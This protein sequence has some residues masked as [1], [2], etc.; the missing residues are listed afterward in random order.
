MILSFHIFTSWYWTCFDRAMP[1]FYIWLSTGDSVSRNRHQRARPKKDKPETLALISKC[2]RVS[3]IRPAAVLAFIEVLRRAAFTL[4]VRRLMV[5]GC[6]CGTTNVL[7]RR[8]L[9]EAPN[10]NQYVETVPRRGYRF[11]AEVKHR[12]DEPGSG[13]RFAYE[14]DVKPSETDS[15]RSTSQ[16]TPTVTSRLTRRWPFALAGL[17]VLFALFLLMDRQ[18]WREHIFS[19]ESV[20][21]QSLAVL[22]LEDLSSEGSE[23]YLA[24]RM[25]DALITNLSKVSSLRVSSRPSVM[26]YKG[27]HKPLGEI[28]RELNV[29]A[30]LTGSVVRSGGRMRITIQL[31]HA[32]T[33]RNLWANSYERELSDV[34]AIQSD[35]TRDIV[36]EIRVK[37]LPQEQVRFGNV[38]PVNPEAF[39]QYLRGQFYLHRQKKGDNETAINALE[40]AVALDNTFAPAYA[41]LSQAYVWKLFL[42]GPEEKQLSEKAFVAAEKAVSLDPDLAVA[43]LARGRL[44]WTPANRFPHENAIQEYNRALALNPNLDEARNQLAL[45]YCHIGAFNEAL[46]ESRKAITINPSNTLAQFRIGQTLNFQGKYEEALTVL[47]AIPQDANPALVGHQIA[48]SLFNLGRREEAATV[49]EN[50]IKEHPED[51]GGL[52]TSIQAVLAASA[53]QRGIAV[54]KIRSAIE[55]GKGFGHFHHT[56]YHIA[57]A[58]AL[59]NKPE[60]AITWLKEAADDGF[61]CYPLFQNDRNLDNMRSDPRFAE[62]MSKLKGQWEQYKVVL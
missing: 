31:A 59:L 18:G 19:K 30:V 41:E 28:G 48:W 17:L 50:L 54:E 58:Y 62:L 14:G 25:T 7:P 46:E 16:T 1:L 32:L 22:P 53:G 51:E 60:E 49:L 13:D 20:R 27:V 6:P 5:V 44:L 43:Y 3:K 55:K 39:D 9:G 52:F 38:G 40:Q 21:I 4:I 23:D 57:C 11:V 2:F 26:Q 61:P 56:A 15:Q 42:F 34:L 36:G 24:D 45:V 33:D 8:A 47:R 37:L 12:W 29:D 10:E 35:V